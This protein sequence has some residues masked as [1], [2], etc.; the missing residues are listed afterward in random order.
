MRKKFIH[1][2]SMNTLQVLVV[3]AC[4]LVIFYLLSTRLEK[5]DFGE[6]N[7]I[8]AVLMTGFS[9]LSFGIEQISIRRIAAGRNAQET[10]S[11]YWTHV[12]VSGL[13]FYAALLV[14]RFVIPSFH[15]SHAL[16]PLL[17][18]GK[19]MLFFSMPFKQVANGLERFRSLLWM[20]V[21]SSLVRS[22]TLILLS[23]FPAFSLETVVI[24]FVVGDTAELLLSWLIMR[25]GIKLPVRFSLNRQAYRA[26]LKESFP[27]LGVTIFSSA[28]ARFDWILLGLLA[29]N[30]IVA[31]YSFAYK[32]FEVATLPLLVIAPVLIPRFTR[33]F[34]VPLTA[35]RTNDLFTL[36]RIEMVIA[37]LF[38]LMLNMLWVPVIDLLTQNKY[39]LVNQRTI[40]ILSCSMPV[41]YFNNFLWTI[42]FA[43]GRLKMIFLVFLV[44]FLLNVA[45]DF[46][47][48][49]SFGAEGAAIAY[50]V[51]IAVQFLLY[52]QQTK[53]EG[54]LHNSLPV[55]INP[56]L[57]ALAGTGA[58]QLI[59][60]AWAAAF[61]AMLFYF[62]LFILTRQLRKTD[63]QALQTLSRS[64]GQ[65]EPG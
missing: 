1:D 20:S 23:F 63:L 52:L 8:L 26:L 17:G 9:I 4:G 50:L 7:W 48:I 42:N 47:L 31:N 49:P 28:L 14:L 13:L 22:L 61:L 56:A 10:L 62:I 19:L 59:D 45:G 33:W 65:P 3:Q 39:G 5:T 6:L 29:G 25:Y 27:Q 12:L 2:I 53:L 11:L 55:L 34:Q 41:L 32:V 58:L 40:L 18:I 21:C 38:A 37:S 30:V 16:F 60:N 36:L 15:Q 57:A 43:R 64:K 51:A 54:L 44:S 46:L 35:N 24:V